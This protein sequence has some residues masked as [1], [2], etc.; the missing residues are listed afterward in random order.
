MELANGRMPPP[1]KLPSPRQPPSSYASGA[2]SARTSSV[3]PP[4]PGG[5]WKAQPPAPHYAT[6]TFG[7]RSLDESPRR[8]GG[9]G[10]VVA[11]S[12]G[13]SAR[14]RGGG[15][16][17][18][19]HGGGGSRGGG[20]SLGG[21]SPRR[22]RPG[23]DEAS[24]GLPLITGYAPTPAPPAVP[25]QRK[26]QIDG[27]ADLDAPHP[28]GHPPL[29]P[30]TTGVGG[31]QGHR[32]HGEAG[33]YGG[34]DGAAPPSHM[35][36][37]HM[38][39]S[40]MPPAQPGAASRV[41]HAPPM[42]ASGIEELGAMRLA[43]RP[44]PPPLPPPDG[45]GAPRRTG[46]TR[47]ERNSMGKPVGLGLASEAAASVTAAEQRKA[48]APGGLFADTLRRREKGIYGRIGKGGSATLRRRPQG[49][50]PPQGMG[51]FSAAHGHSSA[52]DDEVAAGFGVVDQTSGSSS[53]GRACA[54]GRGGAGGGAGAGT[55]GGNGGGG[56]SGAG[57]AFV[58]GVGAGS[59]L[60]AS[61]S[62]MEHAYARMDR[63]LLQLHFMPRE[64][65][66][67]EEEALLAE[68]YRH[69]R[70]LRTELATKIHS[71]RQRVGMLHS[72]RFDKAALTPSSARASLKEG[73]R[74]PL[75]L[76]R[77]ELRQRHPHRLP[78]A[79]QARGDATP[80]ETT[81]GQLPGRTPSSAETAAAAQAATPAGAAELPSM[82]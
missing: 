6:S 40:H 63:S 7:E 58:D 16:G 77:S 24:H 32:H 54:G 73:V 67:A 76:V 19:G 48:F 15:H 9:Q 59:S 64:L 51:G 81:P 21:Q 36:P 20:R 69:N 5:L 27:G 17:G 55:G 14:P 52:A 26:S 35:P 8:R 3:P 50:P 79:T 74:T 43:P 71:S 46:A 70:R 38:P 45:G 82:A 28:Y 47:A 4:L 68:E 80:R 44:E 22:P 25:P 66:A 56:G 53:V 41:M 11:S 39:P 75:E 2:S 65:A 78:L 12:M 23:A 29:A 31:G 61:I 62:V 18:G 13:G 72:D 49:M 30:P 42:M 33:G 10:G 34:L 1:P 37:S 60:D 57:G